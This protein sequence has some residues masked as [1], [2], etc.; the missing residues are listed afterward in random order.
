MHIINRQPVYKPELGLIKVYNSIYLA[1]NIYIINRQMCFLIIYDKVQK[2]QGNTKYI[3]WC[4]LD[5]IS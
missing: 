4:L 1:W 5:K 2:R 3:V